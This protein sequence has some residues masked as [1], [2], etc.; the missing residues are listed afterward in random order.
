MLHVL[1][2]EGALAERATAMVEA[3]LRR[4]RSLV[5]GCPT[6]RT[7]LGLYERLVGS[8]ADR[9]RAVALDEY[10]GIGPEHP[11]SLYGWLDR[12]LLAPLGVDDARILRIEAEAEDRARACRAYDRR[13]AAWGGLDLCILGLGWNGHVAFNEPGS[14]ATSPTRVVDLTEGTRARNRDYWEGGRVPAQGVTIGLARIL[15]ARRI[16]LLVSGSDKAAILAAALRGPMS[17]AVPASLLRR[18]RLTVL[19]D[20]ASAEHLAP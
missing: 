6:G 13:L 5:V 7:P 8:P 12:A 11:R 18:G 4:K 16:L 19:A 14:R 15:A 2:D 20:R 3:A 10:A 17:P 1:P 9:M